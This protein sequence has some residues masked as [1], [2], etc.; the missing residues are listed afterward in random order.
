MGYDPKKCYTGRAPLEAASLGIDVKPGEK[1]Y[2]CNLV[3]ATTEVLEDYSAGHIS[4]EH[5]RDL[6]AQIDKALGT[7]DL[8][9]FPG[10]MYRHLLLCR[11]GEDFGVEATP[12]HD[13]QGQKF[14]PHLPKGK[15][16]EIFRDLIL[17]SREV[18]KSHKRANMIW[19]WGGGVRPQLETFR[20]KFKGVQGGVISAVDLLQGLGH[21][22]GWRVIQVPGATGYFDTDYEAKAK[23]AIDA[24]KELDLI[25]VHVEAT[26]EAGHSGLPEEKKKAIER[27]DEAIVGPLVRHLEGEGDYRLFVAPDHYT[28]CAKKTHI[29]DPVPFIFAGS[30]VKIHSGKSYTEANA[31]AAGVDIAPGHDLMRRLIAGWDVV[32]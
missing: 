32:K 20:E 4:T 23:Y 29:P 25:F 18:L 19:L 15:G 26:D 17:K 6:I 24:L 28:P 13:I 22:V 9:F 3:T 2:R 21:Y 11:R 14:K 1:V 8:K 12:P 31:K 5:A 30:D 10:K 7:E 27:I 16:A